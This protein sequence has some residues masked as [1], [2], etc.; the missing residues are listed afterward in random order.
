MQLGPLGPMEPGLDP[1][2]TASEDARMIAGI[3][4][5]IPSIMQFLTEGDNLQQYVEQHADAYDLA[6]LMMMSEHPDYMGLV[7]RYMQM[8]GVMP[9]DVSA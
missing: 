5:L 2:K 1:R 4:L 8:T 9:T 6:M 7:A 3:L